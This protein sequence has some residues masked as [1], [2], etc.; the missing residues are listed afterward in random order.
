MRREIRN[1]FF[2]S[3]CHDSCHIPQLFHEDTDGNIFG[4]FTPLEWEEGDYENTR[5]GDPSLKSFIFALKNP[6]NVPAQPFGRM[7]A[8]RHWRNG[9]KSGHSTFKRRKHRSRRRSFGC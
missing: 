4:G 5:T 3:N 6:D 8:L 2:R 1:F 9:F 7:R